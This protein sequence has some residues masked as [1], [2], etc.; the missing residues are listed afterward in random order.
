MK[1]AVS[2]TL[3]ALGA[4]VV[5]C[6]AVVS[7]DPVQCATDG[8]CE[9]RGPDF[10]DTTCDPSG[11]CVPKPG[12]PSAP[13]PVGECSKSSECKSK[14]QD[15]LCNVGAH[16]C[17]QMT[18]EPECSVLYGDPLAD[19]AVIFGLLS[20][21]GRNDTLY[22]RQSQHPLAAKL[23]F[24]EFFDK[25]GARF[26]GNR[27]AA[28]I[29]CSEHFPKRVSAYLANLGAKAIIGPT[30]ED[31]QK[32]IVETLLPA[33]VPSFS[34]W[35]NGSPAAVLPEASNFAWLVGFRRSDV[36]LPLNALL[37]EQEAK[38]KSDS[39]GAIQNVRVA[40]VVNQPALG[41]FNAFAEYGDL[42]DQRLTFNGKSAV[43]NERDVGCNNCYKRFSTSQAAPDVVTA[44][45]EEIKAFQPHFI[46]PFADIDWGAQLL[47]KL[48]ELYAK[49]PAGTFKP[50]YLQTFLQIED[51]G[52]RGLQVGTE[53]L[54]KRITGI[55]PLR[56]NSFE[57]FQNKFRE[58]YRPPSAPDKLGPEPNPGAG[59][60]FE[61]AFLLLFATY[62]AM[63]N[64]AD[65]EALPEDV[66]DAIKTI[67]DAA[68]KKI[69]LNDIAE[70]VQ[71]LNSKEKINLEGLFT[72][73]DFDQQTKSA[74][75]IWTTWCVKAAGQYVSGTRVFKDGSFGT[76]AFCG[77]AE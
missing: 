48:E 18:P 24:T 27:S 12:S 46:V 44:K 5:A 45:A 22:F 16:K 77:A 50:I 69:T 37:A 60:A 41:G 67:T 49:E 58:A 7:E 56:D 32:A 30:A 63:T 54:R 73:F 47:P 66:A 59:R 52:Y 39:S 23:A 43:E 25:A 19:G 29:G 75:P 40:V 8:D 42:M 26:P 68:A 64:S 34:P 71:R 31:S 76:P 2:S 62:A 20:Q 17:V 70:G 65:G 33:R 3:L 51:A 57:V 55:R 28:L 1:R 6:T 61:T 10:K 74:P 35:I 14:G 13:G 11:L 21:I 9:R 36:V 38:V 72:F 4:L 53:E 15:F